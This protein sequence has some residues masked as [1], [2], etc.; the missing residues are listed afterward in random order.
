MYMIMCVCVCVCVYNLLSVEGANGREAVEGLRKVRE[1][2]RLG[3]GR[4]H[5][6]NTLATH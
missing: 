5:V 4:N 2:W 3:H 6:S 1:D